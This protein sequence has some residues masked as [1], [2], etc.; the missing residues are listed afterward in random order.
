MKFAYTQQF[1]HLLAGSFTPLFL[2]SLHVSDAIGQKS[3][4][5]HLPV[6]AS[7]HVLVKYC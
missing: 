7:P 5:S 3:L 4:F 2:A 1:I 6:F